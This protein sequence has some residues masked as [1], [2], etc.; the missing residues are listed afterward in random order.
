[1]LIISKQHFCVRILQQDS[2]R[3]NNFPHVDRDTSDVLTQIEKI[4]I[5]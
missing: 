1:M 5:F 3:K 2:S 4:Q